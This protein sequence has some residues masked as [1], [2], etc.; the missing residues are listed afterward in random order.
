MHRKIISAKKRYDRDDFSMQKNL[1]STFSGS[2]KPGKRPASFIK[3]SGS[4]RDISISKPNV[5]L[6]PET[7]LMIQK[8]KLA[9]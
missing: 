1:K 7:Q 5:S 3:R 9:A 4:T 6:D 8:D 2:L